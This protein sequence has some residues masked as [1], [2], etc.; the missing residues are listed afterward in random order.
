VPARLIGHDVE[1]QDG[2]ASEAAFEAVVGRQRD[3]DLTARSQV[4]DFED[5]GI[6]DILRTESVELESLD[7]F[8]FERYEGVVAEVEASVGQ[9]AMDAENV[10]VEL[11]AGNAVSSLPAVQAEAVDLGVVE[12]RP[13]AEAGDEGVVVDDGHGGMMSRRDVCRTSSA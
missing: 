10:N 13:F 9:S 6:E 11:E 7:L 2:A 8:E 5:Q 3:L 12:R 4:D 1:D